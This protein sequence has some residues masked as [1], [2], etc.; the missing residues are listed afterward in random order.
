MVEMSRRQK[1]NRDYL[2]STM[3]V[4]SLSNAFLRFSVLL[5]FKWIPLINRSLANCLMDRV[6]AFVAPPDL[7]TLVGHSIVIAIIA[8]GLILLITLSTLSI[9]FS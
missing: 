5:I 3:S 7:I 1:E 4:P 9:T 6:M 8:T 2:S